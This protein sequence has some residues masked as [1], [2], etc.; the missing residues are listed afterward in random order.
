VNDDAHRP[1]G[2]FSTMHMHMQHAQYCTCNILLKAEC[3]GLRKY[4]DEMTSEI[5][6]EMLREWWCKKSIAV[7]TVSLHTKICFVTIAT[8]PDPDK[9]S[10]CSSLQ[11][12][13]F[14]YL[15]TYS[16]Y[17]TMAIPNSL[18][19]EKVIR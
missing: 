16:N 19:S 6:F 7:C 3:V 15:K 11:S 8:D 10:R 9:L 2:Q 5:L 13:N 1:H 14:Y 12:T 18:V 17:S 4:V